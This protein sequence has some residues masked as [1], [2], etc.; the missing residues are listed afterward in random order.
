[1]KAMEKMMDAANKSRSTTGYPGSAAETN[2]GIASL[3]I[4]QSW[5]GMKTVYRKC[6]SLNGSPISAAKLKKLDVEIIGEIK[7]W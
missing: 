1:M 4:I 5:Y 7:T 6:W 3:T 2:L